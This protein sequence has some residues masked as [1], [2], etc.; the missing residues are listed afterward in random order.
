MPQNKC[1]SITPLARPVCDYSKASNAPQI[2]PHTLPVRENGLRGP[3]AL[4]LQ[5]VFCKMPNPQSFSDIGALPAFVLRA[6]FGNS[7]YSVW[8]VLDERENR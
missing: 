3:V 1:K 7:G 4:K 8:E 5:C 2:L 6:L